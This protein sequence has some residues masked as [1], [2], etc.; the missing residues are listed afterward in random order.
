MNIMSL[1]QFIQQQGIE[2]QEPEC[3][4]AVVMRMG[5]FITALED[6]NPNKDRLLEIRE[7]C[8]EP[9]TYAVRF[10]PQSPE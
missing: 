4:D 10:L 9:G 7:D 2:A 8:P 1:S 6:Q 3:Q 5:D